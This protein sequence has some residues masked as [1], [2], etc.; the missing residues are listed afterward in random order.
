MIRLK[1]EPAVR[2]VGTA[3][4]RPSVIRARFPAFRSK[5]ASMNSVDPLIRSIASFS[6]HLHQSRVR[7]DISVHALKESFEVRQ[8]LALKLL[9]GVEAFAG[10]PG[11][12]A[13]DVYA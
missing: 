13:I 10:A 1:H 11:G 12:H 9:A 6:T 2:L 8:Q 7:A 5:D 4:G 3:A